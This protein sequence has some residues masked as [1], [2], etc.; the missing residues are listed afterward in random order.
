MQFRDRTLLR[1]LDS[2][3]CASLL[4]AEVGDRLMRTAFDAP[5]ATVGPVT[6][7]VTRAVTA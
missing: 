7:V 3:E 6:A 4:T 1:L 5:Q 2:A